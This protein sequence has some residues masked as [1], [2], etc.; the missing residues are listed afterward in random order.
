MVHI[1]RRALQIVVSIATLVPI[2]AG[3]AGVFGGASMLTG[4]TAMPAAFDSHYRYLS[5]LLLA[6]GVGFVTTIPRIEAKERRFRLLAAIVVTG[7]VARLL[8]LLVAG[9][10]PP[11]VIFA[12]A[13]ELGVTPAL[14][15]W[16]RRIARKT[17]AR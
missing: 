3:A 14:V 1:E 12:L 11:A 15:L 6:V 4:H 5:G 2:G 9:P 8:S 10:P 7:G 16:Q 13:M 17:P